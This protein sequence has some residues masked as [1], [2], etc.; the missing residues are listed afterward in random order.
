TSV[1]IT[2]EQARA[3]KQKLVREVK[4]VYYSLQQVESSLRSVQQ[5]LAL[6][7]ELARLT[8]NYVA[9]E[10]VLKADLLQVQTNLAKAEQS[11]LLLY[12]QQATGKEQLNQLLGRDV[13]TEFH[14]Q[15]VLEAKDDTMNLEA[16]RQRAI[17]ARPEIRQ[18]KLRQTQ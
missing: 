6:Y 2:G 12:D 13:L 11:Q 15:P 9:G 4:R 18:A 1:A 8:E 16:A 7:N 10:V 5:T 14:V 3:D 17:E